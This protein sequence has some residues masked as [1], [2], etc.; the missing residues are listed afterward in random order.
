ME[1]QESLESIAA[2]AQLVGER[3][4]VLRATAE[5]DAAAQGARAQALQ[6]TLALIDGSMDLNEGREKLVGFL[7]LE[8]R[9]ALGEQKRHVHQRDAY[10]TAM[11]E[12]GKVAQGAGAMAADEDGEPEPA[13]EQ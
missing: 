1:R 10:G 13:P 12:A 4:H 9:R 6:E 11:S 2:S 5:R 8:I 7:Q 3:I